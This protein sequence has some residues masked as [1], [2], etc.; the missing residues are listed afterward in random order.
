M[1]DPGSVSTDI[2]N[3][4]ERFIKASQSRY[5]RGKVSRSYHHYAKTAIKTGS[6][7]YSDFFT[8]YH[9]SG[10]ILSD[11]QKMLGSTLDNADVTN[12]TTATGMMPLVVR[13]TFM[14]AYIDKGRD[15]SEVEY[16][17]PAKKILIKK[18]RFETNL[19]L[20]KKLSK[21]KGGIR[22]LMRNPGLPSEWND[23][24][25][26]TEEGKQV[27]KK[28]DSGKI[29]AHWIITNHDDIVDP[30]YGTKY[31]EIDDERVDIIFASKKKRLITDTIIQMMTAFSFN[32]VY[33]FPQEYKVK[34]ALKEAEYIKK[35]PSHRLM[36]VRHALLDVLD[37]VGG[38]IFGNR[39]ETCAVLK[40][41]SKGRGDPRLKPET[42]AVKDKAKKL[43]E[44]WDC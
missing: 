24:T 23:I 22:V 26:K 42:R 31:N 28:H 40:K 15:F 14:K 1:I 37:R 8:T 44:E 33:N 38:S 7:A 34:S 32:R 4:E 17:D 12:V 19:D 3:I 39:R 16:D 10:L 30:R 36:V 29:P 27:L 25:W 35:L 20:M 6:R 9:S 18:E 41:M 11:K 43:M 21:I 13:K 5:G 2:G